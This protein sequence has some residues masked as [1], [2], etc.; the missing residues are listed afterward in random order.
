MPLVLEKNSLRKF[1][2]LKKIFVFWSLRKKC[3]KIIVFCVEKKFKSPCLLV[4][5]DKISKIFVFG[6]WGKNA[7]KRLSSVPEKMSKI[8]GLREKNPQK[9]LSFGPWE[10]KF[11]KIIVSVPKKQNS[12]IF[13]FWSLRRKSLL[14]FK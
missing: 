13:V 9:F 2:I 11:S 1:S 7:Q 6:P 8:F 5:V 14:V 3:P 10:K 12:K 4:L